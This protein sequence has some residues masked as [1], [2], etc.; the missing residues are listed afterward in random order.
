MEPLGRPVGKNANQNAEVWD[1]VE[2]LK[3]TDGVEDI[4]VNQ[5]Q[6]NANGE[7]VG[8]NRPDLQYIDADSVRHYIE[9]D[10]TASGRGQGHAARLRAND[11]D[12][13]IELRTVD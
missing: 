3:N 5:Q 11:P 6:V 8:I 9:W 2:R 1:L 12:G 7:R 13:I 4:R 10:T